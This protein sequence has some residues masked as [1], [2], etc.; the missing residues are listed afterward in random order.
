MV[1]VGCSREMCSLVM[2]SVYV[3]V[4]YMLSCPSNRISAVLSLMQQI[5]AT[6]QWWSTL[7]RSITVTGKGSLRYWHVLAFTYWSN[8]CPVIQVSS[9]IY[10]RTLG[11]DPDGFCLIWCHSCVCFTSSHLSVLPVCLSIVMHHGA[12]AN[13]L[14]NGKHCIEFTTVVLEIF[15]WY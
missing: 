4:Y 5:G 9:I 12:S 3:Y 8:V 1:V 13:E 7:Y 2:V 14:L 15:A 10:I 6:L 11:S